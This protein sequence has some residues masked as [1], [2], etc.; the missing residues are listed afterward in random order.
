LGKSHD[1]QYSSL[2]ENIV[3]IIAFPLIFFGDA[4]AEFGK[5]QQ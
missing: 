3:I 5:Q 1:A 4:M 2:V